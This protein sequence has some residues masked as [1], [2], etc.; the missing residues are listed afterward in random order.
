[1]DSNV[2]RNVHVGRSQPVSESVSVPAPR[3][4]EPTPVATRSSDASRAE[5]TSS[6]VLRSHVRESGGNTRSICL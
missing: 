6:M 1:M 5:I 3:Q 2:Q 4:L